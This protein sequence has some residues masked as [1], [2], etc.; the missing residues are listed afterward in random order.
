MR[1]INA[2]AL[3]AQMEADVEQMDEPLMRI[4][5]HAAI[6]DVKMQPTVELNA[7]PLVHD[8]FFLCDKKPGAC[9]SWESKGWTK[10]MNSYCH[11]TSRVDHALKLPDAD[12]GWIPVEDRLPEED[13]WLGGSERQ[14]SDNVLVSVINRDDEDE[15]VDISQTIDGNWTL[16]LPR[17][18]KIIAW[19]PLPK[20]Y[21]P[22]EDK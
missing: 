11:R 4:M 13:H 19:M 3:I 9:P 17:H 22:K 14:F 5:Y 6:N 16:E 8:G 18:C 20:P 1:L 12:D 7:E 21:Q 2:D 10:C 15:W